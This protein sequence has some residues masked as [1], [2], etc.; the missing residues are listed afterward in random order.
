MPGHGG[1]WHL[2][3]HVTHANETIQQGQQRGQAPSL[4]LSG[5]VFPSADK[6]H[7]EDRMTSSNTRYLAP[8]EVDGPG[9]RSCG[10]RWERLERKKGWLP[11]AGGAPPQGLVVFS[12]G[13]DLA[14]ESEGLL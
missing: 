1:P 8:P 4:K 13:A 2:S 11:R 7:G 5:H 6:V 12:L 10:P 9:G 14:P 3:T